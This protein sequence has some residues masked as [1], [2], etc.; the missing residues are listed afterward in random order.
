M[1]LDLLLKFDVTLFQLSFEYKNYE[2]SS[3][4]EPFCFI[5]YI[6]HSM[7]NLG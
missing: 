6:L 1:I 2:R 7:N 3:L 4:E 5:Y